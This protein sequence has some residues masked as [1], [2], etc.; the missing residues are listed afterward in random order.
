MRN[1]GLGTIERL[2][3]GFKKPSKD[4]RLGTVGALQSSKKDRQTP[5]SWV[6][7]P[8]TEPQQFI[9]YRDLATEKAAEPFLCLVGVE[10]SNK[11]LK[12]MGCLK[13]PSRNPEPRFLLANVR[14]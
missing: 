10:G 2:C 7:G 6:M 4:C 14:S 12:T 13:P 3:Q 5:W 8:C 11:T 9:E 1:A